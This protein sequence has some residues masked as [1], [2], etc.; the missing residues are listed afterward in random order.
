[1]FRAPDRVTITPFG[2]GYK[3]RVYSPNRVKYPLKRVDWTRTATATRRRAARAVR[4]HLWDEP[5]SS[6]P[7]S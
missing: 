3:A 7:T 2:L 1:V 5:R 6:S 4:P